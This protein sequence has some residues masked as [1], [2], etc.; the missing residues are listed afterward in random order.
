MSDTQI[1]L[2]IDGT[3]S[4]DRMR[5]MAAAE[6]AFA[7]AGITPHEAATA[8]FAREGWDV[9]GFQDDERPSDDEMRMARVWDEAET[10]AFEACCGSDVPSGACMKLVDQLREAT[11]PP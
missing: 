10:A 6:A 1:V 8:H 3:T 2:R 4:Q 9:G 7:A 5:G 11:T